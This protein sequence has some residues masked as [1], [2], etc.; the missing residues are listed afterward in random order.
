MN[1]MYFILKIIILQ[2]RY[3][4]YLITVI[5]PKIVYKLSILRTFNPNSEFFEYIIISINFNENSMKGK[6][7]SVSLFNLPE[8]NSYLLDSV[9][10]KYYLLS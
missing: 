9:S 2:P 3:L 7:N 4:F 6:S 5:N 1:F 8:K 10:F